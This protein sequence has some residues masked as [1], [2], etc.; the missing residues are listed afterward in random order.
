VMSSVRPA[1]VV[2]LRRLVVLATILALVLAAL[3]SAAVSAGEKIGSNATPVDHEKTVVNPVD[4]YPTNVAQLTAQPSPSD[5]CPPIDQTDAVPKQSQDA[6]EREHQGKYPMTPPVIRPFEDT[7]TPQSDATTTTGD[8][9]TGLGKNNTESSDQIFR[10]AR[11]PIKEET[12]NP[13][14]NPAESQEVGHS[15]TENGNCPLTSGNSSGNSNGQITPKTEPCADCYTLTLLKLFKR[16]LPPLLSEITLNVRHI[17]ATSGDETPHTITCRRDSDPYLWQCNPPLTIRIGDKLLIEEEL[18]EGWRLEPNPTLVY[19][20]KD[21][22][23]KFCMEKERTCFYR[24]VNVANTSDIANHKFSVQIVKEWRGAAPPD[25][26]DVLITV[27]T[28]WQS[29]ICSWQDGTLVAAGGGPCEVGAAG[30]MEIEITERVLEGWMPVDP[31]VVTPAE[32]LEMGACTT[33]DDYHYECTITIVNQALPRYVCGDKE[34]A[35]D[36]AGTYYCLDFRKIWLNASDLVTPPPPGASVSLDISLGEQSLG[37]LECSD[38]GCTPLVV[39]LANFDPDTA[40]FSVVESGLP[41]GWQ[42]HPVYQDGATFAKLQDPPGPSVSPPCNTTRWRDYHDRSVTEC[43]L[44]IANQAV[45]SPGDGTGGTGGAGGAGGGTG[46]SGGSA[47]NAGGTNGQGGSTGGASTAPGTSSVPAS[48][49]ASP[50]S[51][52]QPAGSSEALALQQP[53]T[54]AASPSTDTQPAGSSEALA[55][56][57]PATD[58]SPASSAASTMPP[59]PQVLPRTGQPHAL[60]ALAGIGLVLLGCG[61]ILLRRPA[62][63]R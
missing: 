40:V 33:K 63:A 53:A 13:L 31:I 44:S 36:H 22:T 10:P 11:R 58:V 6:L 48:E 24:I 34:Y 42:L 23:Q 32:I 7:L 46:G 47:G 5:E 1:R 28:P 30:T 12:L 20:D 14:T 60:T 15:G 16:D 61:V 35:L 59:L 3:S 29:V 9:L 56:Q 2:L 54:E 37:T 55:L 62:R 39:F 4:V 45:P 18:V 8:E 50:R 51:D 41:R 57:Q 26:A 17:S 21:F 27:T 38:A 52:A 49:A 25:R 43:V 19:F